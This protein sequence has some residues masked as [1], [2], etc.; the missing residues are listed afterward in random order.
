VKEKSTYLKDCEKV[1]LETCAEAVFMIVV[2]G[3]E[4]TRACARFRVGCY[5]RLYPWLPQALRPHA[6][7]IEA[8]WKETRKPKL[9]IVKPE[10]E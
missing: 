7:E 3:Y 1:L 9:S 6:D 8:N 10:K 2:S 4:G 5:E